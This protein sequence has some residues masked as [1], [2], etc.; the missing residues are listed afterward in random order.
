MRISTWLRLAAL[1]L[2]AGS[3]SAFPSPL[4]AR[5]PAPEPKKPLYHE[6]FIGYGT[7]ELA[8]QRDAL[9]QACSWVEQNVALGWTPHPEYLV[10]QKIVQFCDP[11]EKKFE[12]P[13]ND[14]KV[15]KMQLDI[16]D[17][18]YRDIQ[19][20]AQQ[21]RMKERQ[22]TSLLVLIGVVGLLGV[23]GGYLRLDEAT[24]GYCTRLLRIAAIGVVVVIVA[25]LF[26][27]VV[28]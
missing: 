4:A 3:L 24:K 13:M 9:S 28:G 27:A 6:E 17:S 7:T 18:Q 12:P 8:A 23:I 5:P 10:T 19:K 1:C 20:Q 16:T 14:M 25:G 21:V 2:L 22:Y 11:E 26:L 15:V